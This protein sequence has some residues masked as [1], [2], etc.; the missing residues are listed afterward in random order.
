MDVK[1][2]FLHGD[3]EDEIYMKHPIGFVVK[4]KKYSMCKLKRS[5]YGLK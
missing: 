1:T 4:G 3:L 5:I 2:T